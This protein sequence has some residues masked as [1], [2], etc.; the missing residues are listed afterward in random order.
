MPTQKPCAKLENWAVVE[1]VNLANFE[2]LQAGSLLV[3]KVYGHPRIA[4]GT[5]IFTSAIV[6][7]DENTQTAETRNTSYRL[8]QMSQEYDAWSDDREHA[9]AA[10]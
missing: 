9:G 5:F 8:G 1:S 10:A 4:D 3:G 7:F 6:R 2:A